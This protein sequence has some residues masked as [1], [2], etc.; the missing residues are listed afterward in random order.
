MQVKLR[1]GG[2]RLTTISEHN[3]WVDCECGRAAP[4]RV[5]DVLAQPDPPKTVGELL[6]K[7]RCRRCGRR[8]PD[9]YRIVYDGRWADGQRTVETFSGGE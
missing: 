4:I 7:A 9:R 6:A 2:T 3:V 5:A 1:S 8:A